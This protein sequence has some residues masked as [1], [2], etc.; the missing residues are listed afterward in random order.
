[1][2]ETRYMG[3][4][5]GKSGGWA[6]LNQDGSVLKVGKNSAVKELREQ[7][8]SRNMRI[9]LE[10]VW[11]SPQMGVVG[12]F[13]FGESF[14]YLQGLLFG[15]VYEPHIVTPQ[16]WQREM[17]LI[18][19][20]RKQGEGDAAKKN[21]NKAMAQKLFPNQEITHAW[22]DALLIA[23]YCRRVYSA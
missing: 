7:L 3:I 11:S 14:G 9:M 22:A 16:Y 13:S 17:G 20:G 19:K 6:V 15:R 8:D 18:Q 12:A 1:M 23:E 21:A 2:N 4:D 5:P 10:K